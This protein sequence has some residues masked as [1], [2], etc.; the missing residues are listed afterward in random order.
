MLWT[1]ASQQLHHRV[2]AAHQPLRIYS[3]SAAQAV[4][5]ALGPL[6]GSLGPAA[7]ILAATSLLTKPSPLA[8]LQHAGPASGHPTALLVRD[9]RTQQH[10][11]FTGCTTTPVGSSVHPR[12][13]PH[14]YIQHSC[15]Q[16]ALPSQTGCCKPIQP[17]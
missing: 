12:S 11:D 13:L 4:P 7:T 6:A 3:A 15:Q 17:C 10:L 2:I 1:G 9:A 5:F 8:Y 16:H 14:S